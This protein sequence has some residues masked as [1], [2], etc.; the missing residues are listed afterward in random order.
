MSFYY[1]TKNSILRCKDLL[2][3]M[4]FKRAVMRSY[5]HCSRLQKKYHV[6]NEFNHCIKCV[7]LDYNCDLTFLMMK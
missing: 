4:S 1:I 3:R 5:E 2:E 6:N 7:H